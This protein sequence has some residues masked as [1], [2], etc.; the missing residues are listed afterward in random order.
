MGFFTGTEKDP[1]FPNSRCVE[2]FPVL[3]S[4]FDRF[5]NGVNITLI[6]PPNFFSWIQ[7]GVSVVNRY[8][9]WQSYCTFDSLFT[10]LD[11][12]V[13]TMEGVTNVIYRLIMNYANILSASADV[14]VAFNDRHCKPMFIGIGRIFSYLLEFNVPEDI[15]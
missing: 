12:S 1:S 14:T 15:V 13:Q 8:A 9:L 6:Y 11:N 10:D 3:A 7:S 2:Y 5:I 4:T